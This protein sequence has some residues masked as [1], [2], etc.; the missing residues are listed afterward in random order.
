MWI[1]VRLASYCPT[2]CSQLWREQVRV[3]C[4]LW[5]E[6]S[7]QNTKIKADIQIVYWPRAWGSGRQHRLH[8]HLHHRHHR[9][10]RHHHEVHETKRNLLYFSQYHCRM[11]VDQLYAMIMPDRGQ[12]LGKQSPQV[13]LNEGCFP[14]FSQMKTRWKVLGNIS[15][16]L[17][18]C[19]WLI[20]VRVEGRGGR[21]ERNT[22]NQKIYPK[23]PESKWNSNT[24]VW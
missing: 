10:H 21:Q 4:C 17:S 12:H 11:P 22:E 24:W 7:A 19:P 18:V 3:P 16:F 23:W 8:H 9:H 2:H 1:N 14:S 6:R 20:L 5:G 15:L 13:A